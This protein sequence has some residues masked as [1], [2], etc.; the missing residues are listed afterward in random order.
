MVERGWNDKEEAKVREGTKTPPKKKQDFPNLLGLGLDL[1]LGL[2]FADKAEG[3]GWDSPRKPKCERVPKNQKKTKKTRLSKLTGPGPGPVPYCPLR[4][5]GCFGFLG[6]Q[7]RLPG[8]KEPRVP[9]LHYSQK[10]RSEGEG[11]IFNTLLKKDA[12]REE[13]DPH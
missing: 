4:A 12:L 8:R 7:S 10:G 3:P 13:R 2:G 6:S 9:I 5:F 11:Q 1:G